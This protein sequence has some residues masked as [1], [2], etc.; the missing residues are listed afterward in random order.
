[1]A[2]LQVDNETSDILPILSFLQLQLGGLHPTR[3]TF[4]MCW[5]PGDSIEPAPQRFGRDVT[6]MLATVSAT[7]SDAVLMSLNEHHPIILTV[8]V[9]FYEFSPYLSPSRA[10]TATRPA[11]PF[12]APTRTSSQPLPTPKIRVPP[13]SDHRRSIPKDVLRPSL[14]P[15]AD[16][17]TFLW[18]KS[19]HVNNRSIRP[20]GPTPRQGCLL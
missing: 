6:L 1:M 9:S 14:S 4:D 15:K 10:E 17:V 7:D 16:E 3:T 5:I 12:S 13:L 19:R 11:E 2:R 8:Y 18:Q 20:S